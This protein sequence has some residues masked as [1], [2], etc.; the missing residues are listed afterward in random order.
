M[1]F[2]KNMYVLSSIKTIKWIDAVLSFVNNKLFILEAA[3]LRNHVSQVVQ[4]MDLLRVSLFYPDSTTGIRKM[5]YQVERQKT[6]MN[7]NIVLICTGPLNI[8]TTSYLIQ[9]FM[10]FKTLPWCSTAVKP[11]GVTQPGSTVLHCVLLSVSQLPTHCEARHI[12][13]KWA[14]F[15]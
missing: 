15:Q 6:G 5:W 3:I 8:T 13:F 7:M 1:R 10:K 14:P 12:Y 9:M 11:P 4:N 2:K